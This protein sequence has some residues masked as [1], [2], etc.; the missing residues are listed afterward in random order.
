MIA[1][2]LAAAVETK[3]ELKGSYWSV[4][5]LPGHCVGLLVHRVFWKGA[6]CYILG[7]YAKVL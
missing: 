7:I 4:L 5:E 3:A 1:K 2:L 6:I